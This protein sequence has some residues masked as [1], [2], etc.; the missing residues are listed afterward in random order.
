MANVT[1]DKILETGFTSSPAACTSGGDEFVNSGIEFIKIANTHAS[2]AYDVTVVAQTTTIK[3]QNYGNLTKSNIEKEVA[4]G[5]TAYIGPFKQQAFNDTD[6]KVQ[7]TYL[8]TAGAALSTVSSG[9]HALTIE[10]LYLE[11]I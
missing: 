9:V 8:T 7:L 5:N 3:H 6:S 2:Q 1:P 11:Q 4:A 10:I